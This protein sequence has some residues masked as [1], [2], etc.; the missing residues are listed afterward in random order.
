MAVKIMTNTKVATRC[1]IIWGGVLMLTLGSWCL[2]SQ[3]ARMFFCLSAHCPFSRPRHNSTPAD[4]T[5]ALILSELCSQ[6]DHYAVVLKYVNRSDCS[7]NTRFVEYR[8]KTLKTQHTLHQNRLEYV[9][10]NIKMMF[11]Q[12]H[13]PMKS[14]V[15]ATVAPSHRVLARDL[16]TIT[17]LH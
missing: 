10:I 5:L 7:S 16:L 15:T 6:L 4:K 9:S 17:F 3:G 14:G 1:R 2:L 13:N 11:R 12:T 8:E